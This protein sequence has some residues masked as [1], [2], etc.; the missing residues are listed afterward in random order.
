MPLPFF[1]KTDFC[2]PLPKCLDETLST[3][4]GLLKSECL[5]KDVGR[6]WHDPGPPQTHSVDVH[7]RKH[8]RDNTQLEL[9]HTRIHVHVHVVFSLAIKQKYEANE[10]VVVSS[11]G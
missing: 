4:L 3:H 9:A 6:F 2:S 10:R 1:L 8:L 11:V 5:I 7:Q